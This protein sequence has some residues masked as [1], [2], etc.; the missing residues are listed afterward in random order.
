MAEPNP[1]DG[2][3]PEISDLYKRNPSGWENEA[4]RRTSL[5]ATVE[6]LEEVERGLDRE[7]SGGEKNTHAIDTDVAQAAA[8]KV[9]SIGNRK[10]CNQNDENR[11]NEAAKEK[12]GRALDDT[13]ADEEKDAKRIK[14]RET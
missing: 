8:E 3:V 4:R 6:K 9:A 11:E 12:E 14:H 7:S 5:E 1:D 2:L 13:N 10:S